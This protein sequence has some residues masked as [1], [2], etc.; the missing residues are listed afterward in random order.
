MSSREDHRPLSA[1]QA[2]LNEVIFEADTAPGKLFD[3][4]LIL[5][6]LTSVVVVMLDSVAWF[7][8]RY[9]T[10]L[11]ALEWLFTILFTVEYGLRL[12]CVGRPLRYATS[13]F[14]V[15][16]LLAVIPT[17]LSLVLAGSQ[18]MLVIRILRILRIFRVLKLVNYLSEATMLAQA[19][20]DS[21]RKITVFIF[22]VLTL[23]VIFGSLMYVIEGKSSGFTSIPRS[24]Y[25]AVVTMTTV[26][27]GDISPQT[28][29]GQFFSAMVM[30]LGYS[31]IAVPTG[32]FSVELIEASRRPPNTRTCPGCLTEGHLP[33]ARY[34]RDCGTELLALKPLSDQS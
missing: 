13:F 22:A 4:L 2:R 27:Y 7:N 12:S 28:N 30:I 17:Y 11:T 8:Q 5:S 34:C 10:L 29:M 31:I 15:V 25:W 23:V 32:I 18:Y 16:D 26:G 20:R 24:I 9:G 14:G 3:V 1:W 21:R 33:V 6:I 19:L